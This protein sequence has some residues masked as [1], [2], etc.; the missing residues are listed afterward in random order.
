MLYVRLCLVMGL[1]LTAGSASAAETKAVPRVVV[2]FPALHSLVLQVMDGVAEPTLLLQGVRSPHDFQLAPSEA[3]TLERA[4]VIIWAGPSIEFPLVKPLAAL[5]SKARILEIDHAPGIKALPVRAG[6]VWAEHAH[7]EHSDE[8]E[9]TP[10]DGHVWLD[11]VQA[12]AIVSAIAEVLAAIDPSRAPIYKANAE[13]TIAALKFL[14]SYLMHE[15]SRLNH[16]PFLVFHDAYHYL[17]QRYGLNAAGSIM[18]HPGE[19]V[20]AKR[21]ADIQRVI[22]THKVQ[23]ILTEP[24]FPNK[25][26]DTL[27]EGT[28]AKAVQADP[29]GIAL[30]PGVDL[31]NAIFLQIVESLKQCAQK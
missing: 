14:D 2:T 3:T 16:T 24:Q 6:G 21:V 30:T 13:R 20:S 17:E 9:P 7:A 23:C 27:L 10:N 29:E 11:P 1:L 31:Y 5:G 25:L 26:L 22:K 28:K 8:D 19:T 18:L 15:F 12:Q 4:D